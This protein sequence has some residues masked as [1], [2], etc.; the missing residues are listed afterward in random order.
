MPFA[1]CPPACGLLLDLRNTHH[2]TDSLRLVEST[3]LEARFN[4]VLEVHVNVGFARDA[5]YL[6]CDVGSFGLT[7][8][9]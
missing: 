2:P 4:C 1:S 6:G 3:G 7:A 9:G 8:S 5:G